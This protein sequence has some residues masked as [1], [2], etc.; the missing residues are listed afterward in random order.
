MIAR[1]KTIWETKVPPV[2]RSF[3]FLFAFFFFIW[4]LFFDTNDLINQYRSMRTRNELLSDKAYYIEKIEEVKQ[5]REA[6]LKNKRLLEKFA[7]ERYLMKK[8]TEDVYIIV[9]ED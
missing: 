6:L 9:E 3:Y 4:L 7:R 2:F 8:Q 1:L 5:E